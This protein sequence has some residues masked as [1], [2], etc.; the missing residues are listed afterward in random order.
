MHLVFHRILSNVPLQEI[1]RHYEIETL[2]NKS[3]T[4]VTLHHWKEDDMDIANLGFFINVDPINNPREAFET[5][6]RTNLGKANNIEEHK[7]PKF[8]YLLSSP[9]HYRRHQP[10]C[11]HE[12]L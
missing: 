8:Q 1:R 11:G 9:F 4:Q 12:S 5:S 10:L 2:L 3:N 7:L 6:I